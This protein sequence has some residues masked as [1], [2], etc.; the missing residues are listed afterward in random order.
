MALNSSTDSR[1]DSGVTT[2]RGVTRLSLADRKRIRTLTG[3]MITAL[4][5]KSA[6]ELRLLPHVASLEIPDAGQRF[7]C[8]RLIVK[9]PQGAVRVVIVA[10]TPASKS[11]VIGIG[12]GFSMGED[13][14]VNELDERE[15]W[16]AANACVWHPER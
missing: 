8:R 7:V 15:V 5:R 11:Q 10:H 14:L 2:R 1:L 9:L 13:G 3:R 6:S 12:T 4:S 16:L